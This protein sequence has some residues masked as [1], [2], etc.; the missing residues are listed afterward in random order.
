MAV[1][2]V[3]RGR[4]ELR[5]EGWVSSCLSSI[6]LMAQKGSEPEAGREA[7]RVGGGASLSLCLWLR[8]LESRNASLPGSY[9]SIFDSLLA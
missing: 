1:Y 7:G 5:L 8:T 3:G 4:P 6:F 9:K 2:G